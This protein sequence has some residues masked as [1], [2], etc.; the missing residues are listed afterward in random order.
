ME[1]KTA[2]QDYLIESTGFCLLTI[3]RTWTDENIYT[4]VNSQYLQHIRVELHIVWLTQSYVPEQTAHSPSLKP[5]QLASA[6][7]TGVH[8]SV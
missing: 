3:A 5:I 1:I 6:T 7:Q 4:D 8:R 2:R